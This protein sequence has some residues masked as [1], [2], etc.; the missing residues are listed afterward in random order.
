MH[1]QKTSKRLTGLIGIRLLAAEVSQV[2]AAANMA[3]LTKSQWLRQT[4]LHALRGSQDTRLILAEVIGARA[5]VVALLAKISNG[6]QITD[7][8]IK[9]VIDQVNLVKSA[10]ADK[11]IHAANGGGQ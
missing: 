11:R 6:N 9:A 8:L 3:G 2:E 7:E 10:A 5:V 4:I 1:A